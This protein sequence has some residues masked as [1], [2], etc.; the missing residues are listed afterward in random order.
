MWVVVMYSGLVPAKV[1][2][3]EYELNTILIQLSE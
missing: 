1:G 2:F 3:I